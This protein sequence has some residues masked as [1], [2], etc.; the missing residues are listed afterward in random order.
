[1]TSKLVREMLISRFEEF[2][3]NSLEFQTRFLSFTYLR[4]HRA[5]NLLDYFLR[6]QL[7]DF[8]EQIGL[9]HLMFVFIYL[10]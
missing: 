8:R 5:C 4:Q 2:N 9:P 7:V 3:R 1:M 6:N 10:F